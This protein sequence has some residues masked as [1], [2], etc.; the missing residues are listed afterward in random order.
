M[1]RFEVA[2]FTIYLD[3]ETGLEW[4]GTCKEKLDHAHALVWC[5]SLGEGWRLPTVKEY[6]TLIDY[7][8]YNPCTIMPDTCS[9][10]YWSSTTYQGTPGYAWLVYFNYGFVGFD[11]K[12][13]TYSVR[14]VRGG[15]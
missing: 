3:N 5:E 15:L 11:F 14:A 8:L 10:T 9:F 13:N 7:N 6:L 4:S 1:E 12:S 2:S